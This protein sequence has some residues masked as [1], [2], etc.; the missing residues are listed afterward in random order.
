M[1]RGLLLVGL[2]ACMAMLLP[3]RAEAACTNYTLS[4]NNL[5]LSNWSVLLNV[6]VTGSATT[7]TFVSVTENGVS[8]VTSGSVYPFIN[9][10]GWGTNASTSS[11]AAWVSGADGSWGYHDGCKP[12]TLPG[13]SPPCTMDGFQAFYEVQGQNV[14][15][16]AVWNLQGTSGGI[17]SPVNF[18]VHVAFGGNCTGYFSNNGPST[19]TSPT[20]SDCTAVPEPATLTLLGTGLI[21]LAGAI[22]RRLKV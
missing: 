20:P 11:L 7:V 2:L 6:C 14:L 12:A 1:K 16:G 21:G 22:R 5:G 18:T 3:T 4:N 13:G 8:G 19:S 17:V 15:T 10:F 9:Q